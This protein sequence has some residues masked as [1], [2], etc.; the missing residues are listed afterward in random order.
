ME[1]G[2]DYI[3]RKDAQVNWFRKV[4]IEGI[5]I[6]IQE[7]LE[8]GVTGNIFLDVGET[9]R[10]IFLQE[11]FYSVEDMR[12]RNDFRKAIRRVFLQWNCSHDDISLF[13]RLLNLIGWTRIIDCFDE[14]LTMGL[15]EDLKNIRYEDFDMHERLLAVL[16]GL[17]KHNEGI[18]SLVRRDI[19][20]NRF[21]QLCFRKSWEI[22]GDIMDTVE[23][24]PDL[25]RC[26][27]EFPLTHFTFSQ[28]IK[29]V[30]V[31][32]FIENFESIW[33]KLENPSDKDSFREYLTAIGVS[34]FLID[35][36]FVF[37]FPW[38][39]QKEWEIKI[40]DP[41]VIFESADQEDKICDIHKEE[42]EFDQMKEELSSLEVI[43]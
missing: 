34:W 31:P 33:K 3:Y 13:F 20:D 40:K 4:G 30:G 8:N 1:K 5:A 23:Y 41:T 21:T 7:F 39:I 26:G 24:L 37:Y 6:W 25:F 10:D 43:E 35:D 9:E 11:Y 15:N 22:S 12:F 28:F 16:F 27:R 18:K 36:L 42:E 17:K 38:E 19:K 14:L 29:K 2:K 32:N